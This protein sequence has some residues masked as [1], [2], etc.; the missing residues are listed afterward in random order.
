MKINF[1]VIG[2]VKGGTTALAK[3]L[4]GH[5]QVCMAPDK[6]VRY[7]DIEARY[8]HDVDYAT[9]H[10]AF[11][12]FTGQPA[13]GEATPG[14]M[15]FPGTMA[16]IRAYNPDMKLI[17]VLRDPA[18]RAFSHHQMTRRNKR[19][20]WPFWLAIRLEELRLRMAPPGTGMGEVR[21]WATY[22]RR[23]FY[24]QQLEAVY[25][26]FPR[27]QVLLLRNEDLAER[28]EETM[29][30]VFTFLGV[31]SA[32]VSPAA[33]HHEGNYSRRLHPR[34]RR[35]LQKCYADDLAALEA[36]SG[37]DLSAWRT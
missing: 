35:F 17:A 18:E 23:G 2:T 4:A 32:F 27:D 3:F 10:A 6:E 29:R 11:P 7:F 5:P 9:Y 36:I 37:W 15:Y 16:R 25:Q 30:T 19:E 21:R 12:N 31:D 24:A 26:E 13:V 1:L 20:R 28:H 8:A 33:R 22:V 34:D 14:Y